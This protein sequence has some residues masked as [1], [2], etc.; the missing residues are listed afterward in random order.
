MSKTTKTAATTFRLPANRPSLRDH[1]RALVALNEDVTKPTTFCY[2]YKTETYKVKVVGTP[3]I[4]YIASN[5]DG[6]SWTAA[7][8]EK[9]RPFTF[10][11]KAETM[12]KGKTPKEA[13]LKILPA[14][15]D[16]AVVA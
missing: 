13:F 8:C 5:D 16:L 7:I 3:D 14:F 9:V 11:P 10:T 2:H 15:I 6:R 4:I 1:V 12:T